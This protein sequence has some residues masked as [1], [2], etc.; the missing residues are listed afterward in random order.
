VP[1]YLGAEE[2]KLA[3]LALL[4]A[5]VWASAWGLCTFGIAFLIWRDTGHVPHGLVALVFAFISA[6][7]GFVSGIVYALVSR[8]TSMT[9]RRRRVQVGAVIGAAGVITLVAIGA[10]RNTSPA[11]PLAGN[12]AQGALTILV[13]SPVA[14]VLGGLLAALDSRITRGPRG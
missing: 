7:T 9:S 13:F 5:I 8:T 2:L 10:L 14:A 3:G 11:N 4:I 1:E 6:L 12:L